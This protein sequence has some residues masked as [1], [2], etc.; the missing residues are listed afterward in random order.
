[1]MIMMMMMYVTQVYRLSKDPSERL[2]RWSS[3]IAPIQECALDE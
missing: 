3:D 2:G 1:M